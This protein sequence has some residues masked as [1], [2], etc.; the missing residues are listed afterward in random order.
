M[1]SSKSAVTTNRHKRKLNKL[2]DPETGKNK[3]RA[4]QGGN[5]KTTSTQIL[6]AEALLGLMLVSTIQPGADDISPSAAAVT[7]PP[8]KTFDE[9]IN[10]VDQE[11]LAGLHLQTEQSLAQAEVGNSVV[12]QSLT[13][14]AQRAAPISK[15]HMAVAAQ[16]FQKGNSAAPSAQPSVAQAHSMRD[17]RPPAE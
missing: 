6:S 2:N 10:C 8:L 7:T 15:S 1:I 17:R 11:R 9:G 14:E 13:E 4:M 16:D 12:S 5:A 3:A